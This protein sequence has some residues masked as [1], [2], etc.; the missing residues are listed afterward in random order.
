MEKEMRKAV[1]LTEFHN[2]SLNSAWCRHFG[3]GP[4]LSLP[5]QFPPSPDYKNV[6][7]LAVA[8]DNVVARL[9]EHAFVGALAA[10]LKEGNPFPHKVSV[11]VD[12]WWRGQ[13][14]AS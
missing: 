12:K 13:D 11:R 7:V 1:R 10:F 5:L 8:I 6:V 14:D 9:N 3:A 2:E 4:V